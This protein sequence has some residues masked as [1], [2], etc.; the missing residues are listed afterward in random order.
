MSSTSFVKIGEIRGSKVTRMERAKGRE[1]EK[2]GAIA[3]TASD[4]VRI[5]IE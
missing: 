4:K 2:T 1:S 5:S 3:K